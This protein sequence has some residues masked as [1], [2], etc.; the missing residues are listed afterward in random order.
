MRI[1]HRGHELNQDQLDAIV[2]VLNESMQGKY[3]QKKKLEAA[4]DAALVAAGC[5]IPGCDNHDLENAT[6]Y[7][8]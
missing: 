3:R 2:P 6:P 1:L 5:P 8:D 4:V 7:T